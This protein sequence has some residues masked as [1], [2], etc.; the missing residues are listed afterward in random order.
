MRRNIPLCESDLQY[1]TEDKESYIVWEYRL[2]KEFSPP[3][4][5]PNTPMSA[6]GPTQLTVR[7]YRSFFSRVKAAGIRG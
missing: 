5:A 6:L 4:P 2:E 1:D 3:T 7:W